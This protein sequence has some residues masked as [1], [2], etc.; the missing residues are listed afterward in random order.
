MRTA[1]SPPSVG[2]DARTSFPPRDLIRE[3]R[4]ERCV[5]TSIVMLV[6][7][8]PDVMGVLGGSEDVGR[9]VKPWT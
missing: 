2:R 1:A 6:K 8:T 9:D 5:G 3:R 7:E 4:A